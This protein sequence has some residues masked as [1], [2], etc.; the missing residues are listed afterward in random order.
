MTALLASAFI[1]NIKKEVEAKQY[2][3]VGSNPLE[4]MSDENVLGTM[5]DHILMH[6]EMDM[7]EDWYW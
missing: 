6:V 2:T 3:T 7:D 4:E 5:M 1:E